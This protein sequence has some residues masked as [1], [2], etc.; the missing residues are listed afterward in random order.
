MRIEQEFKFTDKDFKYLKNLVAEEAGIILSDAKRSM[1]YCRLAKRLR[2]L[3]LHEFSA[4]CNILK[5]DDRNE[6]V[7][8]VNA[9]TTNL[10]SFFREKHHFNFLANTL[11][12]YWKR[13][14]NDTRR[15]RI[16]SAGCS[17]GEEAYSIAITLL[18]NF[19][20]LKSWDVK[21]LATDLDTNVVSKAKEGVYDTERMEGFPSAMLERWFLK[22]KN[23]KVNKVKVSPCLQ[24][25]ITFKQLN[26]HHDWPFN[27]SFDLI[28]CRNVVIYFNKETQRVLADRYAD[29]L[30]DNGHLFLGHSESLFNVSDRFESE[31][32]TV[33]KKTM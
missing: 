21:I 7:N 5:Q 19:P 16:W 13:T 4:Y 18:D 11:I 31:G 9:I 17:T 29:C 28:F 30:V 15:I 2:S 33:Y 8:F 14:K 6:M 10:T 23:S 24:E 32:N 22:S 1:V 27:G 12:P 26:L 20:D 25:L 3:S